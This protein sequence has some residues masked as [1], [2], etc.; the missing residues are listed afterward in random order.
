ME[1]DGV[2][3]TRL[4]LRKHNLH[5]RHIHTAYLV[6]YVH[7][8]SHTFC[9]YTWQV[10]M[11]HLHAIPGF[12]MLNGTW[13]TWYWL[14]SCQVTA[15]TPWSMRH[16]C[17]SCQNAA[18]NVVIFLWTSRR[19]FGAGERWMGAVC[20][21]KRQHVGC[22]LE[23]WGN[24]VP[25]HIWVFRMGFCFLFHCFRIQAVGVLSR[26]LHTYMEAKVKPGFFSQEVCESQSGNKANHHHPR[27]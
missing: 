10:N 4:L 15:T 22:L 3:D 23:W 12:H 14:S 26:F 21:R 13:H 11:I 18:C 5:N 25:L 6:S 1:F 17:M 19:Q 27:K 7:V 8:I 16:R 9:A 20:F 2:L 24:T